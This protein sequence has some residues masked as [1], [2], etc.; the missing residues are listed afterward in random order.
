MIEKGKISNHWVDWRFLL[1]H[2]NQKSTLL[3]RLIGGHWQ[4]TRV[5]LF[6]I[7]VR[8]INTAPST[9]MVEQN[10]TH[11][12][13]Y[14]N[15]CTCCSSPKYTDLH[16]HSS[17]GLINLA[18]IRKDDAKTIIFWQLE[19]PSVFSF[20]LH[21]RVQ[22]A[23][24]SRRWPTPDFPWLAPFCGMPLGDTV[25]SPKKGLKTLRGTNRSVVVVTRRMVIACKQ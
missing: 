15:K 2:L 14:T 10:S 11:F 19:Y 21:D 20:L 22:H 17:R 24:K 25:S 5:Y 4:L 1:F 18:E 13:C 7:Q 16:S 23:R 8:S 9:M 12:Y 6:Q 3:S